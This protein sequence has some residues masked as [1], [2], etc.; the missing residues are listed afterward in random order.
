MLIVGSDPE[1]F[2]RDNK[3][4]LVS[5]LDVI[6]GHKEDPYPTKNGS[7]QPDNILAEFNSRPAR[8]AIEFIQNHKL[9]LS[10]LKD[11]IAPLDLQLDFVASAIADKSLLSDPRTCVAGCDPDFNVWKCRL[12]EGGGFRL[13]PNR[14][15]N[16]RITQVRAAGGHLHISF[17]QADDDPSFINRFNFVKA[18]DYNLGVMSVIHDPDNQRRELYGKA[19]SFRPKAVEGRDP[20]NGV[21]YRTLS[22]FW[23]RSEELMGLV[24]SKVVEVYENLEELAD[25][26]EY[27]SQSIQEIINKGDSEAAKVFC[28]NENIS[29][30]V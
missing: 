30:S 9:I 18:L 7:V 21:E 19:G 4:Q 13:K 26:A 16:Y 23:L 8:N 28:E 1:V 24:Y 3:G 14:S 29:W 2:L 10:D 11:I 15:A 17:D 6:P 25:K 5:A 12:L 22:N 27:Y 20:Y